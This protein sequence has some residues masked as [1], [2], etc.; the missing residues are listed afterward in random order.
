MYSRVQCIDEKVYYHVSG[1][2]AIKL[3]LTSLVFIFSTEGYSYC[4]PRDWLEG[5]SV[6]RERVRVIGVDFDTY[7]SQ[8]GNTCPK[9][10]FKTS[11]VDRSDDI[12]Q[13]LKKSGVGQRP[14]I[15]VGHS[16]GG[17]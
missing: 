3:F 17:E 11:L 2:T 4:W 10:S 1:T 9:E 15:F 7:L 6:M 5:D 13:K 14:V 12:L 8:W 16:M